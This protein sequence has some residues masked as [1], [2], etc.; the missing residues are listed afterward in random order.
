MNT[1]RKL[2]RRRGGHYYREVNGKT[3]EYVSITNLLGSVIRKKGLEYWQMS[4]V[5][6]I[7]LRSLKDDKEQLLT[8]E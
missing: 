1:S 3:K 5:I 7:A 2:P 4:E 8:K 6:N